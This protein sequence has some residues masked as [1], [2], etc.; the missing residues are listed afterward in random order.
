MI[1]LILLLSVSIIS[2][3]LKYLFFIFRLRSFTCVRLC[4]TYAGCSAAYLYRFSMHIN[5]FTS[6]QRI[7][8]LTIMD[9]I[10]FYTR[11]LIVILLI[12]ELNESL[13]N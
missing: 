13:A 10:Y 1:R 11:D 7:A 6:L 3:N 4:S 2:T 9:S 8:T 5:I 12:S